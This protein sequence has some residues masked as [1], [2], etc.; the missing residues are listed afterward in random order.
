MVCINMEYKA[1]VVSEDDS[2]SYL[3]GIKTLNIQDLPAGDVLIKVECS[4]LNFKDALSFSGNKGVT[5]KFPHTPGIDAAGEVV[6]CAT[7]DFKAGQK[8][9]VVGYDLGM[10]TSGGFG[11]YISVPAK[12][13]MPMPVAMSAHQSMAW[14]TAGFTAALCIDKLL[15]AGAKKEQGPVLVSGASGGVGSIAIM[16]LVK[17]GFEV[18]ALT[19]KTAD[20]EY[21]KQLGVSEIVSRAI[22]KLLMAGAKKEQGPVL[23]SGA[24]GGVGGIAIMLLVKLGFEVHALTSKTADKEYFKQLGV[25]EI[26]SRAEFLK[27][28]AKP[29]LKPIYGSAIDVAG[30]D[31]LATMLK[32]IKP[33]GSV[34]CCGLVASIELQ[35]TVLPFILRGINLLGVD[36]VELPLNVKQDM[37]LKMASDWSLPA[38]LDQCQ[39]IA[40]QQLADTLQSMLN[41]NIKG[42]Y[43]LDHN[44]AG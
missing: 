41:G 6:S 8:V 25:S 36:S 1:F 5:R 2:G 17:L 4:S 23:V 16:L 34:A 3:G 18:H 31:V 19:S 33:G 32:M 40:K 7:D 37:W 12:W 26:V 42:R 44:L 29:M 20:K 15:M 27:S 43:V 21:F 13:V 14:G 10:N 38:L 30:G 11:E 28:S 24:S 39:L 35:T 9:L 22:D